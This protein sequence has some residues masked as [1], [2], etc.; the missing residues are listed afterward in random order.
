MKHQVVA[1]PR[2]FPASGRTP[3]GLST[4]TNDRADRTP[5]ALSVALRYLASRRVLR[6]AQSVARSSG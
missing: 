5:V 6:R 1:I 3:M 2:L 4:S